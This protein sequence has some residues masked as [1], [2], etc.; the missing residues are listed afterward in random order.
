MN[1]LRRQLPLFCRLLI[2]VMMMLGSLPARVCAL[3]L[4]PGVS[5]AQEC[6]EADAAPAAKCCD[7]HGCG[8]ALAPEP[9]ACTSAGHEP[10]RAGTP[11][12]EDHGCFLT[13][14]I[15][16]VPPSPIAPV[17]A[18]AVVPLSAVVAAA[19]AVAVPPAVPEDAVHAPPGPPATGWAM[20]TLLRN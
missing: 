2:P 19:S 20:R 5:C 14:A 6:C 8:E 18:A 12:C 1:R 13:P 9:A 17:P 4:T 16:G 7:E 10:D 3:S 15:T 11:F